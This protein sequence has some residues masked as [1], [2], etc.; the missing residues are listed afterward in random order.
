MTSINLLEGKPI[1]TEL[2]EKE[3]ELVS[4][5]QVAV[6]TEVETQERSAGTFPPSRPEEEPTYHKKSL[7][8][9]FLIIGGVIIMAAVIY[10]LIAGRIPSQIAQKTSAP[11]EV[12]KKEEPAPEVAE[13]ESPAPMVVAA[14]KSQRA[15]SLAG[16]HLLTQI[17]GALSEA[18]MG[19]SF[20]SYNKG[21]V[22]V[23]LLT[24]SDALLS[25]FNLNLRK[26][27]PQVQLKVL[28]RSDFQLPDRTVRKIL[29]TGTFPPGDVGKVTGKNFELEQ[30]N[31]EMKDLAEQQDL[32]LKEL[33]VSPTVAVEGGQLVPLSLKVYGRS[34]NVFH[35]VGKMLGDYKNIGFSRMVV[36]VKQ[37]QELG[38]EY[39]TA[40]FDI[41]L[42][43]VTSGGA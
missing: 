27:N 23:E 11:S 15:C 22:S 39:I 12:T 35:F 41:D 5:A 34:D 7:W 37:L 25:T 21:A 3:T 9:L 38:D 8:S 6:P 30:L 17:F 18:N 24:T 32:L 4:S 36:A 19:L 14:L 42:F 43:T 31:S 20:F 28:A 10:Y 1:A 16:S 13:V 29:L 33:S 26:K 40:V 2:E